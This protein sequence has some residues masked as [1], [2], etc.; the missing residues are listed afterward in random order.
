MGL[1]NVSYSTLLLM[2][3][4]FNQNIFLICNMKQKIVGGK[5]RK[6]QYLVLTSRISYSLAICVPIRH[7]LPVAPGFIF[8]TSCPIDQPNVVRDVEMPC[9]SF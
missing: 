4:I 8:L 5:Q 2:Q 1:Q 3:F 9:F 6:R 7:V